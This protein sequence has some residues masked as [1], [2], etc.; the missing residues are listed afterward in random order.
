MKRR[1]QERSRTSLASCRAWP[2]LALL[3]LLPLQVCCVAHHRHLGLFEVVPDR[4]NYLLRLPDSTATPFP[5]VLKHYSGFAPGQDWID[6]RPYMELSVENAYYREGAP[7]HGLTGFLGTEIA[8]YQIRP[9]GGLRLLT[10]KSMEQR[11]QDQLPVQQLVDKSQRRFRRYRF[12]FELVFRQSA[13]SRG[14]VLLGANTK[15][16]LNSLTSR[17]L[18]APESVCG[19]TSVHCTVFPE[20]CSVSLEIGITVNGEARTVMW[21][22]TLASVV[23]HPRSIKMQRLYAGRMIPLQVDADDPNALRLPLLPNDRIAWN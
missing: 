9:K 21:G 5:E 6:L 11:P 18:Q 7:K 14:S 23:A 15:D 1:R 2:L 13:N 10:V 17:L 19:T 22:S 16:E 12:F 20:A 8:L 3:G 4:P